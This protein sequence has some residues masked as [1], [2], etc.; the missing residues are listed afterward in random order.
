VPGTRLGVYEIA[1]Q[2]GVGGMGEVYRATDSNL[3]RSVAIKVLPASVAG[4]AD[5][6]ARFQRE[7]EVLA[8][9]NHPNIGAIYGLEKTPAFTALV[10]ELVEGHDLSQRIARGRIPFDEAL[11]IAKQIAD[12]LEAAHEQGIIH[13]DLKPANIKVRA[14]GTVKVLD[15]G[16]AKAMEPAASASPSMSMSPT[17][18]TPVMTQAGMI[19]GTAAYMAPEQAR[20]KVV[21]K[22]VDIWAFGAVLF[23]MLTGRT[24]FAADTVTDTVAAVVTREPD[25]SAVPSTIPASIHEVLARCLEK[26]PKRRLRDIG[27]VRFEL[28]GSRV[29]FAATSATS[30]QRPWLWMAAVAVLAAMTI[31]FAAN[32]WRGGG[33]ASTTDSLDLAIAPPA[34]ADFFGSNPGVILSPDGTTIAF[35]AGTSNVTTLWVRSL[36]T[37]N[38]RALSGTEGALYPFWSPDG[39]RI[40]FFANGKLR[41]V[42][43]AGGLPETIADA[44]NGRGGSWSEDGSIIFT[45]AGG[46][47]IVRVAATGGAVMPL[48]KLDLARGEDAHY[49]PVFLPGGSRFL[50]FARSTIPE[51]SGIYLG[52]LD[53]LAAP[54]RVVAALSS[55]VLAT[56]PSTRALY[57]LWVRDGDLLAQPS[58]ADAGALRGVATT[59]VRGVRVQES[60]RLTFA[61]ASRTGTIVWATAHADESVFALYDRNG[62]RLRVLDIEPG[63]VFEPALSRDGRR[64]LF[65]RTEKG[66]AD[67]FLHD[68]KAGTTQRVTTSPEY[69][70]LP[71]WTPDGVAMIHVG[72]EKGQTVLFRTTLD[73]GAAPSALLR[74]AASGISTAFETPDGRFVIY[75]VQNPQTGPGIMALPLFGSRTPVTVAVGLPNV[76]VS[77]LSIDAQWLAISSA[78]GGSRTGAVARLITTGSTPA[79]GGTFPLGAVSGLGPRLRADGREVFVATPDGLLKSIGLTPTGDGLTLGAPVTLF[80]L[81]AGDGNFSVSGDG[82]QFVVAEYPFAAGQ[83]LRVLTNWEKRLAR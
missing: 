5:R 56:G 53:G 58:D 76:L 81:P 79:L 36:A 54:V 18:T 49:W 83:T 74:G 46:A 37:D 38:A 62:R 6:L 61:A 39:R 44:P 27:D 73:A 68:L 51:N 9:L 42:E 34:G 75:V 31:F 47:S 48:S 33:N 8:A 24:A 1:A 80:K 45:P 59:L 60:Q 14:D 3:K 10:M 32:S 29:T 15:F 82:S 55:G 64:L 28:E 78:V 66:S 12:A 16:L 20:G 77:A 25:W 40:G 13:R 30:A 35:V 4:D 26:D 50:Y 71:T 17:L 69:D 21:D 23:E 67:V 11:P 19:L 2:I 72:R 70:E 43:I 41:T 22:R 63:K 57:L 65:M 7:A 52:R